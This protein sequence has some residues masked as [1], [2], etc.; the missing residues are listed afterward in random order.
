VGVARAPGAIGFQVADAA[1]GAVAVPAAVGA[2]AVHAGLEVLGP[3][4]VGSALVLMGLY[5]VLER[6]DT[7]HERPPAALS[8]PSVI[9]EGGT[10]RV[11][12][13]VM[14]SSPPSCSLTPIGEL[15][16]QS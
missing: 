16:P 5:V 4:L 1:L 13:L 8:V 11:E 14:R 3:V 2:L 6:V 15:L 9:A 7:P 10:Q 12:R